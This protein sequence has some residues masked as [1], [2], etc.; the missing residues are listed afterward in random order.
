MRANS[1]LYF[2]ILL[3]A[4]NATDIK[5]QTIDSLAFIE[6]ITI[7]FESAE[8]RL[9]TD[10][11]VQIDNL[12]SK[13]LNTKLYRIEG[14]TDDVGNNADNHALS[15]DR[16]YSVMEYLSVDGGVKAS[17]IKFKGYGETKPIEENNSIINKSK[18]RRTELTIIE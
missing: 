8:D 9:T 17:R 2:S 14:H 15:E 1:I 16:A 11:E 6:G 12:I 13:H 7:L 4:G 5:A 18:N 10:D 3:I